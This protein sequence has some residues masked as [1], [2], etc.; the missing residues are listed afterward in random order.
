MPQIV[1][2]QE[3]AIASLAL[4]TGADPGVADAHK[5]TASETVLRAWRAKVMELLVASRLKEAAIARQNTLWAAASSSLAQLATS[6]D[7]MEAYVRGRLGSL[8]ARLHIASGR[9]AE[10]VALLRHRDRLWRAARRALDDEK[11]VWRAGLELEALRVKHDVGDGGGGGGVAAGLGG[12]GGC[13]LGCD[14]ADG[15]AC[16]LC[17]AAARRRLPDDYGVGEAEV[18]LRS[19]AIA[20]AQ[21]LSDVSSRVRPPRGDWLCV[22]V[23]LVAG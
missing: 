21:E 17:V 5:A 18:M 7:T 2:Q 3:A 10:T 14:A 20:A 1:R 8:D 12:A 4:H 23:H 16:A 11:R 22:C 15:A 19:Q 13:G 6:L 9:V